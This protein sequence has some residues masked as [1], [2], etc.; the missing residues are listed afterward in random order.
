MRAIPSANA[1]A[2]SLREQAV[3]FL[4]FDAALQP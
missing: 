2:R 4:A 1:N 3:F